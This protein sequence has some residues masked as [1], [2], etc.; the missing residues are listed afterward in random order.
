MST[1]DQEKHSKEVNAKWVGEEGVA[2]Q[3]ED[4]SVTYLHGSAQVG[5]MEE[6]HV[7]GS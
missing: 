6:G 7:G 4:H 1:R 5:F 3:E 2:G